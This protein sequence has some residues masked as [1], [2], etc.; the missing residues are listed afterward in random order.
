MHAGG[1]REWGWEGGGFAV[2]VQH[3][4]QLDLNQSN[5]VVIVLACEWRG[6]IQSRCQNCLDPVHVCAC[7][8]T[9]TLNMMY[10]NS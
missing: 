7:M 5:Y 8:Y 2:A 6:T 10:R 3:T 1:G 9:G 4:F